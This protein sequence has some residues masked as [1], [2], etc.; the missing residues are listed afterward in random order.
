MLKK[1][2]KTIDGLS[3]DKKKK[4]H[5]GRVSAK[6]PFLFFFFLGVCLRTGDIS[7]LFFVVVVCVK[8]NI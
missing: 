1:R 5:G 6:S 8:S 4:K 3:P 2:Q 7:C